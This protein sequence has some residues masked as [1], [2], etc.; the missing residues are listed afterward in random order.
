VKNEKVNESIGCDNVVVLFSQKKKRKFKKIKMCTS[1]FCGICELWTLKDFF[2]SL[3]VHKCPQIISIIVQGG[4]W[5][6]P[7]TILFYMPSKLCI[8]CTIHLHWLWWNDDYGQPKLV[9]YTCIC[10][11]Q[12]ATSF[13]CGT[14]GEGW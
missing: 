10:C 8:T 13:N 7:H 9:K 3:K 11:Q 14:I 2:Q 1:L 6:R 5:L 4:A 12:V